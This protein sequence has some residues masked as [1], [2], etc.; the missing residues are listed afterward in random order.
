MGAEPIDDWVSESIAKT[1]S[2]YEVPDDVATLL[3]TS[4][5]GVMHERALRDK[6]EICLAEEFLAAMAAPVP[7]QEQKT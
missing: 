3:S 5:R 2:K 6:E 4:L 7:E 1:R